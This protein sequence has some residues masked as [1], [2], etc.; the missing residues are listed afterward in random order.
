M[1]NN[2]KELRIDGLSDKPNMV[3]LQASCKE[4][5]TLFNNC[6]PRKPLFFHYSGYFIYLSFGGYIYSSNAVYLSS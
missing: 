2:V 3:C 5:L 6:L 4:N 1:A